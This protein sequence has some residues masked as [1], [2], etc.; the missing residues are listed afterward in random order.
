MLESQLHPVSHPNSPDAK[1]NAAL[2]LAKLEGE[3]LRFELKSN[4]RLEMIRRKTKPETKSQQCQKKLSQLRVQTAEIERELSLRKEVEAESKRHVA[5]VVKLQA[6]NRTLAEQK[7]YD[8]EIRRGQI[9]FANVVPENHPDDWRT[10]ENPNVEIYR[11]QY[12][13]PSGRISKKP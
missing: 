8:A 10:Q 7:A 6:A 11:Q 4:E 9:L 5:A 1:M 3:A 2:L 12:P 13:H